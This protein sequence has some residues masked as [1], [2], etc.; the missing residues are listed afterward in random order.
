[1]SLTTMI[2]AALGVLGVGGMGVWAAFHSS[3]MTSLHAK[4]DSLVVKADALLA[5]AKAKLP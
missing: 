3:R 1:M 4:F 2:L 5:S